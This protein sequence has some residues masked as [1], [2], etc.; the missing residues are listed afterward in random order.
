MA[1]VHVEA[2]TTPGTASAGGDD[3]S[4]S[5]AAKATADVAPTYQVRLTAY[6]AVPA[7]TDGDPSVTASGLPSN[8][9][10]VA[11]R[12]QDLGDELPFGTVIKVTRTAD[13]TPGCNFHKVEPLIGYR[14]I[15]DTMNAR[16]TKRVDIELDARDTVKVDG[17]HINPAEALGLCGGVKVTVVGRIPLGQIPDTQEKLASLFA[18]APSSPALAIN[19]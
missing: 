9:E 13:D 12:S 7:Q 14:V 2:S 15:A 3:P 8:S 18:D 6:N 1:P 16:W 17:V 10:V 4:P 19:K 5:P 11:A